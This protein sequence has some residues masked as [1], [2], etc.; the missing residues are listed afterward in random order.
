[1]ADYQAIAGEIKRQLGKD[2]KGEIAQKVLVENISAQAIFLDTNENN[3]SIRPTKLHSPPQTPKTHSQLGKHKA[4]RDFLPY[5]QNNSI[6][7]HRKEN[8]RRIDRATPNPVNSTVRQPLTIRRIRQT[9]YRDTQNLYDI[10]IQT[11]Q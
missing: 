8:Q 9:D 7:L 11:D 4:G 3:V 6:Q 2:A 1:M 5:R 10:K